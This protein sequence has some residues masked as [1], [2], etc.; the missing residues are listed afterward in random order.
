MQR[1][2]VCVKVAD[3]ARLWHVS[4]SILKYIFPL[5]GSQALQSVEMGQSLRRSN[6]AHEY[7]GAEQEIGLCA[8][9]IIAGIISDGQGHDDRWIDLAVVQLGK[10]K[11]VIQEYLEHSQ[12]SV[13]LAN[14]TYITR[15]MLRASLE[16]EL[17]QYMAFAL[18]SILPALSFFFFFF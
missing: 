7:N 16:D 8:Q 18:S 10:S 4:W 15:Q 9:T 2:V 17:S 1:F 11:D 3:A 6:G 13:L 12:E 14:L 5:D